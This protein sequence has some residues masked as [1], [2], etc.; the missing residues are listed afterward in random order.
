MVSLDCASIIHIIVDSYAVEKHSYYTWI[1]EAIP[2]KYLKILGH[3]FHNAGS[4][5]HHDQSVLSL[6]GLAFA[7]SYHKDW[8]SKVL[9]IKLNSPYTC[10]T[11]HCHIVIIKSSNTNESHPKNIYMYTHGLIPIVVEMLYL[12]VHSNTPTNW[13]FMPETY[14]I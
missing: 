13:R 10:K 3:K 7:V 2:R 12:L 8:Q 4:T 6:F 1:W 5:L 9:I 11:H 14:N